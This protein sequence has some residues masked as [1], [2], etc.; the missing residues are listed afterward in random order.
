M[1]LEELKERVIKL[2]ESDKCEQKSRAWIAAAFVSLQAAR[3][4]K[5][6]EDTFHNYS[7]HEQISI[8]KEAVTKGLLD[9]D[10]ASKDN[11]EQTGSVV[12]LRGYYFNDA[13]MRLAAL[14][15]RGLKY[16]W[17][18]LDLGDK[19][20]HLVKDKKGKFYDYNELRKWYRHVFKEDL[21]CINKVRQQV[22]EFKHK[23]LIFG[24][25][26]IEGINEAVLAFSEVLG[27]LEN[28]V[29]TPLETIIELHNDWVKGTKNNLQTNIQKNE[30]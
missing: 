7:L 2:I 9:I 11:I 14:A 5:Y 15:E 13:L 10:V 24:L 21:K 28:T 18:V 30:N 1:K 23:P 3:D 17:E 22:N 12:W 19:N 6:T 27:V 29:K 16:L 20:S 4:L 8:L 26:I 25:N